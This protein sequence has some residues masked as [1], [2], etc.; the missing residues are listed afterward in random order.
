MGERGNYTGGGD[1]KRSRKMKKQWE[2]GTEN[3]ARRKG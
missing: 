3:D 2:A 1:R